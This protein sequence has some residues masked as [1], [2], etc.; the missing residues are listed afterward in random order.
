MSK[1]ID[2]IS[3]DKLTHYI[4]GTYSGS[5]RGMRYFINSVASGDEKRVL[6]LCIWPEPYSFAATDEK[7]KEFFQ[8]EFTEEGLQELEDK[9][10]EVYGER[11]E[12]WK[13]KAGISTLNM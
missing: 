11:Q 4:K 8:F 6:S 3:A 5:F 13:K 7:L 1:E 9:L 12:Y 2:I 10:N